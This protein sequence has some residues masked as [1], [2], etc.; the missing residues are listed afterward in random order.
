MDKYQELKTD[1][2]VVVYE[3]NEHP[4]RATSIVVYNDEGDYM[5]KI[6]PTDMLYE[7][8]VKTSVAVYLK[9][10]ERGMELGKSEIQ[11]KLRNQ[12]GL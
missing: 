6:Y 8:L 7:E 5:F 3:V 9:G 12:L 4:Q 1:D 11:R 2:M 10:I